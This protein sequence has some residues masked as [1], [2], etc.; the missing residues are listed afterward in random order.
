MRE[1][2]GVM[3]TSRSLPLSN[4]VGPDAV[5]V[6]RTTEGGAGR[7]SSQTLPAARS[8][9]RSRAAAVAIARR[10]SGQPPAGY[11]F[12]PLPGFIA[13]S[14]NGRHLAFV[15]VKDGRS[16]LFVRDLEKVVP[17]LLPGTE[18]AWQPAWSPDSRFVAFIDPPSGG[19]LKKIDIVGGSPLT[20]ADWYSVTAW[21]PHGVI[22]LTGRDGHLYRI[23]ESGGQPIALVEPDPGRQETVIHRPIFLPDGR[24]FIFQAE[25]QNLSKNAL[26]M[27]SIDGGPRTHLLDGLT[28]FAY[29]DGYLLYHR[30]G[31]LMAQPFDHKEARLI[32]EA[33]PGAENLFTG[34]RGFAAFTIADNGTLAYRADSESAAATLT[35]FDQQGNRVGTV[36][37]PG[38][39]QNPQLSRDGRWLAVCRKGGGQHDIW[40]VDLQRNVPVR[41]TTDPAVDDFPVWSDDGKHVIFASS[42]KG[43][44]DL[45]RRAADGSGADEMLFESAENK[46]PTD[47]SPDGRLLL[48]TARNDVWGLP[49]TGERTPFPILASPGS[50]EDNAVFRPDGQWIAYQS[51]DTGAPDI[52]LQPFLATGERIRMSTASATFPKWTA[53]R[54]TDPLQRP[55]CPHGRRCDRPAPPGG[56][57]VA[58]PLVRLDRVLGGRSRWTTVPARGVDRP[59]R[60]G[61]DYR[62]PQLDGGA[63][64]QVTNHDTCDVRWCSATPAVARTGQRPPFFTVSQRPLPTPPCAGLYPRRRWRTS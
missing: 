48:F 44:F 20:I 33:I 10:R 56:A 59:G 38:A 4:A 37:G 40:I 12:P 22:L 52:Y 31:T 35:W 6:E 34:E 51:G 19:R 1:P 25:G 42:R 26:F 14:P 58:V 16:Q 11:T 55:G 50:N 13:I 43:V 2:S 3:A 27:A 39:D 64:T 53:G 21:S 28:K 9:L 29:A 23:P 49:L 63:A 18:G 60:R 62:D 30:E 15:A 45:Y 57:T 24:R 54:K 47:V 46:R 8:A 36:A 17:R 5:I 61:A 7:V 41:L 32:G